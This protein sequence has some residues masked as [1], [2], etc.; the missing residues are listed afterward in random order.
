M[1]VA[2]AEAVVMKTDWL[3]VGWAVYK[4]GVRDPEFFPPLGDRDTQRAWL[5]GFSSAWASDLD[6]EESVD[7]VL[8]L[9]LDGRA[10]LLRQL[11]SH[12]GAEGSQTLH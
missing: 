11:R 3:D 4:E 2:V 8:A 1:V 9:A 5:G 6:T 7:E 10:E 12:A